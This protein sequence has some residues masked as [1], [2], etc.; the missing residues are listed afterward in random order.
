ML[1]RLQAILEKG[2]VPRY[3][4]KVRSVGSTVPIIYMV[5]ILIKILKNVF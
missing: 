4:N 5:L 3:R 2:G 1:L